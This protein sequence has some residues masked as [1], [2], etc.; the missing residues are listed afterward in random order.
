MQAMPERI[1]KVACFVLL[2]ETRPNRQTNS[3]KFPSNFE[4]DF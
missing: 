4:S 1:N 3:L 2:L